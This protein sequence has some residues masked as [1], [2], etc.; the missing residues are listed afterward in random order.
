MLSC[1]SS[2]QSLL[3]AWTTT[4][5]T[6]LANSLSH[7]SLLARHLRI[8]S[9]RRSSASCL[10]RSTSWAPWPCSAVEKPIAPLVRPSGRQQHKEDRATNRHSHRTRNISRW[11]TQ[12]QCL[13]FNKNK[14]VPSSIEF[15]NYIIHIKERER[16]RASQ[17]GRFFSCVSAPSRAAP[18]CFLKTRSPTPLLHLLLR[19]SFSF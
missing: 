5:A 2:F 17:L 11:R 16:E 15:S 1:S 3:L 6:P 14:L 19:W 9:S 18:L 12:I 8:L 13:K 4:P 7:L 10:C